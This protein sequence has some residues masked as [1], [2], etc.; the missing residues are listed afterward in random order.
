MLVLMEEKVAKLRE[1]IRD[2]AQ[3]AALVNG[4]AFWVSRLLSPGLVVTTAE[5]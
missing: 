4:D 5:T 3:E 2:V 1:G